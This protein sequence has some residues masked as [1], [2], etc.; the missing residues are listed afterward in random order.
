MS[1]VRMQ[2]LRFRNFD[3]KRYSVQLQTLYADTSSLLICCFLAV[4]VSSFQWFR[5]CRNILARSY[6]ARTGLHLL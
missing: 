6:L 2:G 5:Q 1:G 4:G 3:V